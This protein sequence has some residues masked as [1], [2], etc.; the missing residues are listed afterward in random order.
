MGWCGDAVKQA[1][2]PWVWVWMCELER[3]RMEGGRGRRRNQLDFCMTPLPIKW[4]QKTSKFQSGNAN[5]CPFFYV[6]FFKL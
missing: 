4:Q 6:F 1:G 3:R 5:K 2:Y